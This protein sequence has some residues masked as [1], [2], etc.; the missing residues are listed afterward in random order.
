MSIVNTFDYFRHTPSGKIGKVVMI[1]GVGINQTKIYGD[2]FPGAGPG[3]EYIEMYDENEGKVEVRALN[4]YP[5]SEVE[6][7]SE[8]ECTRQV[9]G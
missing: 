6:K 4:A 1:F 8:E 5:I 7:I 3:Y 9:V 2:M